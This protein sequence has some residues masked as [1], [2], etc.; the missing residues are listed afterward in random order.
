[1]GSIDFIKPLLSSA[2]SSSGMNKQWQHQ[3]FVFFEK[4]RERQ[5][6]NPVQ[7]DPEV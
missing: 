4:I 2:L 5:E 3:Q 6:L 1:M 7:L